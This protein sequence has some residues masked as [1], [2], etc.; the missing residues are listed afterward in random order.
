MKTHKDM[1]RGTVSIN[2]SYYSSKRKHSKWPDC[3]HIKSICL[4]SHSK[5][6]PIDEWKTDE[7]MKRGTVW[8][9]TSYHSSMRKHSKWPVL[10]HSQLDIP[11]WC[12][13]LHQHT[14][15]LSQVTILSLPNPSNLYPYL[16]YQTLQSCNHAFAN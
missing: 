16:A 10:E 2:T 12:F 6:L 7:D 1:K 8:I 4:S 11:Y 9:N 15:H 5:H 13:S 14:K 3:Y